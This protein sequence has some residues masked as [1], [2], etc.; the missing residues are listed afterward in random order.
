MGQGGPLGPHALPL[1]LAAAARNVIYNYR[2]QRG[3][4]NSQVSAGAKTLAKV[5]VKESDV[6]T[7][8][9]NAALM[10]APAR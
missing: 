10:S 4:I 7:E 9:R 5:S 8:S 2:K 3:M 1:K 6:G